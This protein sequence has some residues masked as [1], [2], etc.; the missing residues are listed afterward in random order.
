MGPLREPQSELFLDLGPTSSPPLLHLLSTNCMLPVASYSAISLLPTSLGP[1]RFIAVLLL[2]LLQS[3]IAFSLR[4]SQWDVYFD[5]SGGESSCVS[6]TRSHLTRLLAQGVRLLSPSGIGSPSASFHLLRLLFIFSS[7]SFSS[8]NL[9]SSSRL[10]P[11]PFP[12]P[13]PP[14]SSLPIS[15]PSP[16]LPCRPLLVDGGGLF[17]F[18]GI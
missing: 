13:R 2:L 18:V 1:C 3:F 6:S 5:G 15:P 16:L 8:S 4:L 14:Y 11:L 9:F 7:F 12:L 17:Y 10:L